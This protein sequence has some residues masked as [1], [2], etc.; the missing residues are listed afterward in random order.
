MMTAPV[1]VEKLRRI[2]DRLAAPAAVGKS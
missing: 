1:D 2:A